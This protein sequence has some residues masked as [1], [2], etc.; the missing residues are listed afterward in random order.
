MC[1]CLHV[2]TPFLLPNVS[3]AFTRAVSHMCFISL[4][5]V[6][7]RFL[8]HLL[9]HSHSLSHELALS[10]ACFFL[11]MVTIFLMPTPPSHYL[12]FS[13]PFLHLSHAC[14]H[15]SCHFLVP[16]H[17]FLWLCSHSLSHPHFIAHVLFFSCHVFLSCTLLFTCCLSL[18]LSLF[19]SFPL[20][21][22]PLSFFPSFYPSF[23]HPFSNERAH[24]F[25]HAGAPA[26]CL[27]PLLS[28]QL[29]TL[30]CNPVLFLTYLCLDSC[31]SFFLCFLTSFL[32]CLSFFQTL[33]ISLSLSWV[34][35]FLKALPTPALYLALSFSCSCSLT[36]FL[37][38]TGNHTVVV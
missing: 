6:Y 9:S 38:L 7:S 16:L 30:S 13:H 26:P 28:S 12:A 2:P 18:S 27:M 20:L 29:D 31:R 35:S 14:M 3:P 17:P 24:S 5:L 4:S 37:I 1:S 23:N 8:S 15:F 10:Y 19:L 33:S 11:H 22:F 34:L 25:S 21:P 32:P 36:L